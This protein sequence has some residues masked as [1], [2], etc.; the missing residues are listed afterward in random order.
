MHSCLRIEFRGRFFIELTA[1]FVF[2]LVAKA[3]GQ[4]G[5]T[6]P[7]VFS[8]AGCTF[9]TAFQLTLIPAVPGD[10]IRYTLDGT[11]PTAGSSLY[12]GPIPINTTVL[13]RAT[14]FRSGL[15]PSQS[16]S[17]GYLL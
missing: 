8:K 1:I 5:T 7:P 13:V 2:L 10:E 6:P 9:T 14:A 3:F 4:T 15:A 16:A 12:T 17:E 11:K